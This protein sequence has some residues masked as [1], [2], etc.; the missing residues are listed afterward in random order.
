VVADELV[1]AEFDGAEEVLQRLPFPTTTQEIAEGGQLGLGDG[2]VEAEVEI[3]PTAAEDVGEEV[4]HVEPGF[5]DLALLQVGGA[6]L[7][8]FEKLFHAERRA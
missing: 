4:F 7:K 1:A 6:G 3:E 2:F 8:D 5:L